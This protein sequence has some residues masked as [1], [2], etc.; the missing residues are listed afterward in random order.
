MT[1]IQAPTLI[2]C[3]STE[4]KSESKRELGRAG[5]VGETTQ[6]SV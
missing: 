1:Q 3:N 2:G 4:K 5:L 6:A